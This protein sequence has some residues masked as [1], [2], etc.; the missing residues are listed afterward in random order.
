[1]EDCISRAIEESYW[2]LPSSVRHA[3]HMLAYTHARMHTYTRI[4]VH[5]R[6][7]NYMHTQY[8]IHFLH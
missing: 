2:S 7:R 8:R 3:R 6:A 1:M 5:T 4:R